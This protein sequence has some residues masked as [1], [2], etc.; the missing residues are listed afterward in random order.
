MELFAAIDLLGGHC[1]RLTEGDFARSTDYGEDAVA[2]AQSFASAGAPWL[3]VVDLDAART[4][5]PVNREIVRA[6]AAA[7]EV[8][9][10]VG[11]GVRSVEAAAA[12]LDWAVAR[13]VV[14]TA[15]VTD[16]TVVEAISARWPGRIAVGLDHR[17]GVVRVRGWQ[18]GAGAQVADLVPLAVAAGASAV[19]VTD[20]SRD[21]RLE[22]PDVSGLEAL[23]TTTGAPIVAS[24]GVATLDDLRSLAALRVGG[25]GLL[26]VVVG[27]A[28]HERRFGVAEAVAVLEDSP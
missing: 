1:V 19:V 7:V 8:P 21:G 28:L 13:V 4:G 24:G 5:N 12:S 18:E 23:L 16:P 17:D 25:R 27:K 26:G 2:V 6:I 15:F 22:G 10:Q 9:V 11:G 14:G 3:H 20:I